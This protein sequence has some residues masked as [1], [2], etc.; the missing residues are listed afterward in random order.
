MIRLF[1]KIRH[2]LLSE[3]K[4][5]TYF[6]TEKEISILLAGSMMNTNKYVPSPGILQRA[7]S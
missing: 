1:R 4:Y 7:C 3:D 6:L 2:H 5:G